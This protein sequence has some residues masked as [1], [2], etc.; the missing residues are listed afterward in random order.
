MATRHDEVAIVDDLL[1]EIVHSGLPRNQIE[2]IEVATPRK[3]Q[4]RLFQKVLLA[5]LV[6]K[7]WQTANNVVL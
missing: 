1:F 6:L 4:R 2:L 5:L 7:V 3:V